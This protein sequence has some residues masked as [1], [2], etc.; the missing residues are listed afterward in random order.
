MISGLKYKVT[1]YLK[2]SVDD[3]G[4]IVKAER[5]GEIM[6]LTNPVEGLNDMGIQN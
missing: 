5:E 4:V 2:Y 6:N 3:E 1:V